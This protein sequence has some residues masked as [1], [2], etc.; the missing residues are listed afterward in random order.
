MVC[1]YIQCTLDMVSGTRFSEGS[2]VRG[3]RCDAHNGCRR[4]IVSMRAIRQPIHMVLLGRT[5]NRRSMLACQLAGLLAQA[6]GVSL[7]IVCYGATIIG[8]ATTSET[9]TFTTGQCSRRA[10]RAIER[11]IPI[12]EDRG[13]SRSSWLNWVET[14][15]RLL[16]ATVRATIACSQLMCS[17]PETQ[18]LSASFSFC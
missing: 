6:S 7:F 13:L 16:R 1:T 11:L 12:L 17:S 4:A 14:L 2:H 5:T 10:G 3:W 8:A 18:R 9:S 15:A